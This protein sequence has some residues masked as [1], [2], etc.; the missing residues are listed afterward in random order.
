MM[1]HRHS[2]IICEHI[3]LRTSSKHKL[4]SSNP[5]T[6]RYLIDNY[7]DSISV[8]DVGQPKK[9]M[10]HFDFEACERIFSLYK[11]LKNVLAI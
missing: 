10:V 7:V 2:E 6:Y 1:G 8:F 3:S 9:G 11:A 4:V 5:Q